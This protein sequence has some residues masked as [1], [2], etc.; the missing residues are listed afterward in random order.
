MSPIY[1]PIMVLHFYA[2]YA[3]DLGEGERVRERERERERE[4]GRGVMLCTVRS[5]SRAFCVHSY[6]VYSLYTEHQ[7]M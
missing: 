4:G 1:G 2:D 5:I 6:A 3:T 7:L